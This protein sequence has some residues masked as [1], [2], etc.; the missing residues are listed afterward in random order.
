MAGF[1]GADGLEGCRSTHNNNSKKKKTSYPLDHVDLVGKWCQFCVS[2]WFCLHSFHFQN[3]KCKKLFLVC[4]LVCIR[5]H[6][7]SA[8]SLLKYERTACQMASVVNLATSQR[9]EV[10][11]WMLDLPIHCLVAAFFPHLLDMMV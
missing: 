10:C 11:H 3:N 4:F 2:G 8:F 6:G 7:V 5:F 9:F 1:G